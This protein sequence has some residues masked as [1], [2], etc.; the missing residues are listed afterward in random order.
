MRGGYLNLIP[1]VGKER[2]DPSH[3]L[4]SH[5]ASRSSEKEEGL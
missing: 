2:R 5:G 1:N 4:G 3:H